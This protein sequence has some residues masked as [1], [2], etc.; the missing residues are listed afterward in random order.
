MLGKVFK[1]GPSKICGRQP[2]P[3]CIGVIWYI[4]CIH[5]IDSLEE[6]QN[7]LIWKVSIRPK[8]EKI[9]YYRLYYFYWWANVNQAVLF[10]TPRW[11]CSVTESTENMIA[12]VSGIKFYDDQN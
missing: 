9:W 6:H 8:N 11:I 2:L 12:N 4:T 10:G 5:H 7:Q 3:L 1:N